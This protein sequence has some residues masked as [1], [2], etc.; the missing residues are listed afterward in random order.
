MKREEGKAT[1][2]KEIIEY[3][4]HVGALD[5]DNPIHEGLEDDHKT[6]QAVKE[7][8]QFFDALTMEKQKCIEWKSL[9]TDCN[10]QM[11]RA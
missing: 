11:I 6:E 7:L 2:E 9:Y 3:E 10:E 8:N 4:R 5:N 1:E